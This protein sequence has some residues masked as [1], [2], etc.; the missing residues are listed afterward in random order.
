M[1]QLRW[2]A[3]VFRY[4]YTKSVDTQMLRRTRSLTMKYGNSGEAKTAK[5]TKKESRYI[6]THKWREKN[7]S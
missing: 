2:A 5:V 1:D 7:A 6:E 4:V 3:R